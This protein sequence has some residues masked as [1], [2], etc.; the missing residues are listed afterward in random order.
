MLDA[1]LVKKTAGEIGFDLVG[2][3]AA[4]PMWELAELLEERQ[5]RGLVPAFVSG[6]VAARLDPG[7]LLPG[8]KSVVMTAINYYNPLTE[9]AAALGLSRST[10]GTDYHLV[11]GAMLEELGQRL[12]RMDPGLR[13]Y[14]FVDTGPLLERELARRAGLGWFGKNASLITPEYGSWVF[15]GGLLVNREL[16]EDRPLQKD[17]AHCTACLKAC[18]SGALEEPYLVNPHRCLSYLTQKK[19]FLTGAEREQL[20]GRVYGCDACQAACP[21]NQK[22]AQ[23]TKHRDFRPDWPE[24]LSLAQLALMDNRTFRR[25]F[26]QSALAWRGK[27]NLK[28]NAVLAL[29]RRQDEDAVPVLAQALRDPAPVVRAHAA[30]ALSRMAQPGVKALLTETLARERDPRVAA[31]LQAALRQVK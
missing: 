16:E 27:S 30:W 26:G 9:Q 12:Q 17:C 29:G 5:A 4:R 11:L 1:G 10:F 20:G 18:P 15:L 22:T 2:I 6:N 19:G 21:V 3:T 25:L 8:A 23:A 13:Y 14:Q 7:L 28:R 31:E 24:D